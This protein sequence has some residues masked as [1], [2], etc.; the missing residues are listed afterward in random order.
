M[1]VDKRMQSPPIFSSNLLVLREGKHLRDLA[2]AF[3]E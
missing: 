1:D 2:I 3:R